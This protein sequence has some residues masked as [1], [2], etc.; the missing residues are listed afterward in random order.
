M[1]KNPK[2]YNPY[3]LW[4]NCAIVGKTNIQMY[5]KTYPKLGKIRSKKHKLN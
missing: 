2:V 3:T 1:R 5:A 4:Q